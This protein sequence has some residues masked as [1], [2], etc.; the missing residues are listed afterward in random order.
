MALELAARGRRVAL[1][2]PGTIDASELRDAG[3]LLFDGGTVTKVPANGSLAPVSLSLRQAERLRSWA[4]SHGPFV[5]HLHEPATPVFG[6]SLLR[7]HR[8]GIVGTFHRS[9]VDRL[10]Q[11]TG[12]ALSRLLSRVDVAVAVSEAAART[13]HDSMD[14]DADVLFNGIDV[15]QLASA[16]PWP[17]SGPTV[18]FLGRDEPRKGRQVLLD[19]ACLLGEDVTVW[20]TG[21][22]GVIQES[23]RRGAR[24]EW[25]GVISEEEKR[26]RLRGAQ[27]LC[28]PSLGGESFGMVLLEGLAAGAT[29]VASDI[30]GYRQALGGEGL[31]VEAGDPARL[32]RALATALESP[33]D[34]RPGRARAS[35][36]SI[37]ALMDEYEG[38]YELA[39]SA[40]RGSQRR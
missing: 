32:A 30:D 26:R 7:R 16:E 21:E 15:E 10:Y 40:G 17:T 19:A 28:A 11:A 9:G 22:P 31:L 18:L 24:L 33:F 6:W 29:V 14:L 25:I 35:R 2:A 13:V 23:T 34:P 4:A 38:R 1:A 27:V 39:R 20:L 3:V 5:A 8:G 37:R 12:P 36:W